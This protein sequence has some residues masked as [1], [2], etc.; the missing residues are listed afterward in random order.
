MDSISDIEITFLLKCSTLILHGAFYTL[1]S[2]LIGPRGFS[3]SHLLS[4]WNYIHLQTR[5]EWA[6][7]QI[8]ACLPKP[9]WFICTGHVEQ[10]NTKR[11]SLYHSLTVTEKWGRGKR[12]WDT[13]GLFLM[14]YASIF[15]QKNWIPHCCI[16]TVDDNS[17]P[18]RSSCTSWK[19]T[20]TFMK[21]N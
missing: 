12:V 11:N 5:N 1:L 13:S 6:C 19:N 3:E 21:V 16:A 15:N 18:S 20:W 14:I 4:V 9:M 10:A 2:Q 17:F 7:W 8:I